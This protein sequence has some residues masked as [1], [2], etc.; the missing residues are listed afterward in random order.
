VNLFQKTFSNPQL[1]LFK[2]TRFIWLNEQM[3]C[4]RCVSIVNIARIHCTNQWIDKVAVY[5]IMP[6]RYLE[7]LKLGL[8]VGGRMDKGIQFVTYMASFTAQHSR[9]IMYMDYF[10]LTFPRARPTWA[11]MDCHQPPF[12]WIT[13]DCLGTVLIVLHRR[14]RHEAKYGI[15]WI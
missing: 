6:W 11:E 12:G 4:H 1:G 14:W 9:H 8:T 2:R 10:F 5:D 7:V 15:Y 3:A 13:N